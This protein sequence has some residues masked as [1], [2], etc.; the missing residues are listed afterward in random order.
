MD[1]GK[2]WKAPN[3][4]PRGYRSCVIEHKGVY[5]AC[6]TTGIDYSLDDGANW[7]PLTSGKFYSLTV[8]KKKLY[9]SATEGRVAQFK[10]KK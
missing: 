3:T 10:L 4:N 8:L 5:Y 6:G 9:A 2:T 1:G 7:K